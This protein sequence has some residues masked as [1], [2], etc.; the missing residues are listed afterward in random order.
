MSKNRSSSKNMGNQVNTNTSAAEAVDQP[1]QTAEQLEQMSTEA[2]VE[3]QTVSEN[4]P[5]TEGATE[6]TTAPAA[7]EH[8]PEPTAAPVVEVQNAAPAIAPTANTVLREKS[9]FEQYLDAVR[10]NGSTVMLTVLDLLTNY[11]EIMGRNTVTTEATINQQQ[12]ALW[13]AVR[14]VLNSSEDFERGFQLLINFFREHSKDGAFQHHLLYR[15]FE[16]TTLNGE[17]SKAFQKILTV[18]TTAAEHKNR[19]SVT[20]SIDLARAMD[21]TVFSDEARSR[22]IGFFN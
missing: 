14:A 10:A 18:I 12:G 4:D 17:T 22:V 13:R 15:G 1:N 2:G 3:K 5:A 7:P 8:T 6:P 21:S 11:Q 9:E 20:K 16:H 19:S